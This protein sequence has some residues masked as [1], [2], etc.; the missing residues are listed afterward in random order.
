[1]TC[2]PSCPGLE[3]I[4]LGPVAIAAVGLKGDRGPFADREIMEVHPSHAHPLDHEPE[5]PIEARS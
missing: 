5:T 3:V 2:R 4:Q 1:M